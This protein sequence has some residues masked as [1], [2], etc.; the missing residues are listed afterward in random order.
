MLGDGPRFSDR[1]PR[2]KRG[3]A[4]ALAIVEWMRDYAT[5]RA[6]ELAESHPVVS[7]VFREQA[8][9]YDAVANTLRTDGGR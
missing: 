1:V 8:Q 2:T 6:T 9:H 7:S 4:R 3:F 5:E